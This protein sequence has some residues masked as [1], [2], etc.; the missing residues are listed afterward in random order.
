MT[1]LRPTA[2]KADREASRLTITWN[3]GEVAEYPFDLLRNSC[4]CAGC[5]GGHANMKKEPDA[6]MFIIPLMDA[7]KL[8]LTDV[9]MVGNY[10]ISI[11]WADGHKDGI[12]NWGYLYSLYEQMKF[13][14]I[15]KENGEHRE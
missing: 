13:T 9:E 4:P 11:I 3:S 1:N 10:A 6:S 8:K 7:N 12:F 14:K 5:R 2:I 15:E